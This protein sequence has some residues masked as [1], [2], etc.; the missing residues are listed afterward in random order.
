MT[1]SADNFNPMLELIKEESEKRHSW[2]ANLIILKELWRELICAL[3]YTFNQKDT[4]R[5]WNLCIYGNSFSGKSTFINYAIDSLREHERL[6]RYG[7]IK[8]PSLT[9]PTLKGLYKD[10]LR[11]LNWPFSKQDSIQ[12][13]EVLVGDAVR[14]RECKL[15]VVDEFNQLYD[16]KEDGIRVAEILKALRNIPNRTLRPMILI[17]TT[18]VQALLRQDMETNSRFR[19]MEFPCFESSGVKWELFRETVYGLDRNLKDT[20]GIDSDFANRKSA[21]KMLFNESQG[22]MGALVKIYEETVQIALSKGAKE[23]D[24]S[25]LQE[26]VKIFRHNGFVNEHEIIESVI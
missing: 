11:Q 7:I 22:K 6:D 15:T 1:T 2:Q 9:N 24:Q 19:K 14:K 17:G 20:A 12:D 10:I 21:L 25:S 8:I 13:L 18:T 23:L 4:Q 16:D 5:P 26:A 3:V